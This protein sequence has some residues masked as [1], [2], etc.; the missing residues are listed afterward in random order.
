MGS[1]APTTTQRQIM[2]SR[3]NNNIKNTEKKITVESKLMRMSTNSSLRE[4]PKTPQSEPCK[5]RSET[6]QLK[7]IIL[8]PQPKRKP[9]MMEIHG[10]RH[11]EVCCIITS[12]NATIETLVPHLTQDIL[13]SSIGRRRVKSQQYE[14]LN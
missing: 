11:S 10:Y 7:S 5:H 12:R 4:D 8:T 2:E 14:K 3:L 9:T 1:C 13:D 6:V